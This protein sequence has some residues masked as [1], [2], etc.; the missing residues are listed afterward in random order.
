VR[1]TFRQLRYFVA[2]G[3]ALSIRKASA[4]VN[5]SE[6]SISSAISQ[7]E[8]EFD[9][10]LFIR[11]H[12]Q[13][14]SLTQAGAALLLDAKALLQQGKEL[15]STAAQLNGSLSGQFT[16]LCFLALAP[17]IVPSVCHRFQSMNPQVSLR[18]YEENQADILDKIWHGKADMAITYDL[19]LPSG[20]DFTPLSSLPPYVVLRHDHPLANSTQLT[21]STL[22]KEPLILLDLPLSKAYFLSLFRSANISP[23]ILSETSQ[24][25]VMRTMVGQGYGYGLANVVPD[26]Q[27]ALDGSQ[28]VYVPLDGTLPSLTLGLLHHA[29]ATRSKLAQHFIAHV[30]KQLDEGKLP[31][32]A[33]EPTHRNKLP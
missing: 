29:S 32:T 11:H 25:D 8:A 24:L 1:F 23:N 17:F 4:L 10:T 26:N 5:V 9:I 18:V 31:G 28:L 12:A 13:G 22:A 15:E 30:Y 33:F 19:E 14:L 20:L 6:P 2:A 21:L 3:D 7:L 16:V 27:S